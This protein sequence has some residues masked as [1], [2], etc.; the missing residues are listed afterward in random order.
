MDERLALV[1][2]EWFV[3]FTPASRRWFNLLCRPGF[4]HC[5]AFRFDRARGTWIWAEL[6]STGML[7]EPLH[8]YELDARVAAIGQAG[9]CFLRYRAPSAPRGRSPRLMYCV[10]FVAH[11]LGLPGSALS[12]YGLYRRLLATGARPA[13]ESARV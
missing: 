7:I 13:F 6:H 1:P 4:K 2:V 10:P 11:L 12:P 3:A 5:L 9:G 8:S